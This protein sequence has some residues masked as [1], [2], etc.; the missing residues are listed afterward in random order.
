MVLV[1]MMAGP[2]PTDSLPSARFR[3]KL[4]SYIWPLLVA[5]I[6]IA[7]MWALIFQQISNDRKQSVSAAQINAT[8]LSR[9]FEQNTL[10]TIQ[11]LDSMII[12]LRSDY[13][14][15]ENEFQKNH[16]DL[17]H[18]NYESSFTQLG[19]INSDGFL[20]YSNLAPAST[21]LDLNDREHFRV[22]KDATQD[23]LFISKPVF[24][25]VSQKW[26]IQLTRRIQDSDGHFR[27]VI[28]MSVSPNDLSR[29]HT[30]IDIG[31]MGAISL[32]GTDGVVR[33]W[34]SRIAPPV[35]PIGNTIPP[36]RPFL[37]PANPD[38]GL[39]TTPSAIDG[40]M[41]IAAYRRLPGFPLIAVVLLSQDEVLKASNT[42]A[43]TLMMVGLLASALLIC[44][45]LVVSILLER[46]RSSQTELARA[47]AELRALTEIDPL[48]GVRNRQSF[49]EAAGM[50]I[51]RQRRHARPVSVAMFELDG[52]REAGDR[53]GRVN[54][55][56]LLAAI[57]AR[58]HSCLRPHDLIGRF[59]G[60]EFAIMLPE[61]DLRQ[62]REVLERVRASIRNTPYEIPGF[63]AQPAT[64][65]VGL[66]ASVAGD[67]IDQML[68]R[69]D[70]ALYQA[71]EQGH[72]S[73]VIA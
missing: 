54:A 72:D 25:R 45:A 40:V 16:D 67:D 47:N 60:E 9:G 22:Q 35:E 19:I 34:G 27:G 1:D 29:F 66:T 11:H 48:T 18:N 32:V 68:G 7:A 41:R 44:G 57:I 37:N 2:L 46:G 38:S 4:R 14:R 28:V 31:Q 69:A 8:N 53:L 3:S 42:R 10:S 56:R 63:P 62:A 12:H 59:N 51:E 73:S 70:L 71:K 20:A 64:I 15:N 13:L 61:T 23:N 50:E 30:S 58:C 39:F 5:V 55:D 24:G 26:T 43:H 17:F 52:Y 33:A 65:S 49:L 6:M 36:D 21:R